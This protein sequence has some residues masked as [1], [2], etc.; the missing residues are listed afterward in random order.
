MREQINPR[1]G[2]REQINPERSGTEAEPEAEREAPNEKPVREACDVWHSGAAR[3]RRTSS[4]HP[5]SRTLGEHAWRR[6]PRRSR[7]RRRCTYRWGIWL[8]HSRW[9]RCCCRPRSVHRRTSRTTPR[10]SRRTRLRTTRR[11]SCCCRRCARPS[12]RPQV[13]ARWP[14]STTWSWYAA[15]PPPP[16]RPRRAVR[17]RCFGDPPRQTE[18][19]YSALCVP[20]W[21]DGD[22]GGD[23]APG[24]TAD[25]IRVGGGGRAIVDDGRRTARPGLSRRRH[26]Q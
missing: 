18:S 3:R 24:V 16:P 15:P 17:G 11:P 9:S 8:W 6:A 12:R 7:R 5:S 1:A 21:T 10:R 4:L 19:L 2:G 23:T 26:R 14:Q 25:E 13:R 22:N 20:A